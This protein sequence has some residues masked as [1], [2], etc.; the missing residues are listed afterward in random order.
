MCREPIPLVTL[1]VKSDPR[2]RQPSVPGSMLPNS[3]QSSCLH[4]IESN[5]DQARTNPDQRPPSQLRFSSQAP[6]APHHEA[7]FPAAIQ[8][9]A[10]NGPLSPKA[11]FAAFTRFLTQCRWLMTGYPNDERR[12]AKRSSTLAVGHPSSTPRDASTS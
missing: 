8:S 2:A 10:H 7:P 5:A 9:S 11:I 4:S 12:N 3:R 6:H 1:H